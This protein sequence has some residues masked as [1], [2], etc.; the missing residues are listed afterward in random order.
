M[1]IT[2]WIAAHWRDVLQATG[3]LFIAGA[4]FLV[5]PA[6]GLALLGLAL[7]LLANGW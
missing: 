4:G 5:Y 6:V 2:E 7:V 1:F 3:Y